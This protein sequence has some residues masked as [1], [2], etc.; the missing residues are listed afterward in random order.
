[1]KKMMIPGLL[2]VALSGNSRAQDSTKGVLSFSGYIET[3]YIYDFNKP[4]NNTLPG[5]FYNHNRA[6]ELNLNLGLLKLAYNNSNTRANLAFAAGTYI[7]ANYTAEPG[8]LK[9]VYEANAGIRLSKKSDLWLD[10]GIFSSHIGFESAI[11]K[12]CWALT[13]SI[14]GDNSPFFETGIKLG[15]TSKDSKWFLGALVLNGWQ[16]IQRPDGNTTPSFGTQVTYKPSNNVTLNYST[17]IGSDKPDTARRMRYFNNFYGIL[18]LNDQWSATAGFDIGME[19]KARGSSAVNT[20]HSPILMI[21][22]AASTKSALA[23]RAEYYA[24]K[25]GVIIATGTPNGFQVWG[26]SLNFDYALRNNAVWRMEIRTLSG[27]DKL[28][29]KDTTVPVSG[30]TFLSTAL[31]IS[32]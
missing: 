15:Y 21:K 25:N 2:L 23:A 28:F 17:F 30:N 4:A 14:P 10:A 8:V 31:A 6:N 32:F 11:G 3:Y 24:D 16:R 22:Y 27:K 12:D 1:M 18:Q 7:N 26:Y 20:W 19:Q 5:F 29:I 13:R 9:N